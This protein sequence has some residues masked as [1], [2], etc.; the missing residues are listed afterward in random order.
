MKRKFEYEKFYAKSGLWA[1]FQV[2]L[3]RL[4]R[5]QHKASL[6]SKFFLAFPNLCI[7]P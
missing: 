5:K 1:V 3:S 2:L 6:H 7:A 4:Q